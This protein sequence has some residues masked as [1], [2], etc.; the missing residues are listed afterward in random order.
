MVDAPRS[1]LAVDIGG[2]FT[3]IVLDGPAGRVTTKV[4]TTPRAPEEGVMDG[5]AAA[6]AMAR[7]TPADIGLFIHGTT[8]ATNALIERKGAKTAFL[9]TAGIRDIL[10]MGYEKRFEQYDFYMDKPAPLVPR[11][12]RLTVRERVS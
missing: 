7:L 1:K 9:T 5:I 6:L 8:L 10:E 3:D 11:P 4:V 12:L 2:A